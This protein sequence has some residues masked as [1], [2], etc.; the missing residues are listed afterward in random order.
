MWLMFAGARSRSVAIVAVVAPGP[1]GHR[2][3]HIADCCVRL[4]GSL[5]LREQ[6]HSLV[7]SVM[8]EQTWRRT[9]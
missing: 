4:L 6:K 9:R 1:L 3:P 2:G 5:F 7:N 8:F